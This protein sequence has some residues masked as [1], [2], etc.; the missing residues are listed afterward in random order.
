MNT[1]SQIVCGL[2]GIIGVLI[3]LPAFIIA[4][5]FVPPDADWTP[6][7]FADFYSGETDRIRAGL[8]MLLIAVVGWG[9]VVSVI[10]VQMLRYEGK[11]PV[12]TVLFA[13]S[14]ITTYVLLTLFGVFLTAAAF[15]PER[16]GEDIQLLHDVGWFMAFLT[17]PAF[18]TQAFAL[19]AA[20]LGNR[21][22]NPVHPRWFGYLN[23]WIGVLLL[24][25]VLL[26]FFHTGP[27]AY[28]GVISYW[29]PLFTFGGW[30][31]GMGLVAVMAAQAEAKSEAAVMEPVPA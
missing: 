3:I 21:S 22:A 8:L 28:H 13:V 27:F 9:T 15:R 25:G 17:A 23:L 7:Q 6:E 2:A 30:M 16:S 19:G 14:G 20:V 1:R 24:P 29:I 12:L 18:A 31:A 5:Y 26:L 10:T 11:R 4:D